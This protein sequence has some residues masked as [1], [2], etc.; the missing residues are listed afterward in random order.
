MLW[1]CLILIAEQG[2]VPAQWERA[3][4]RKEAVH[5]A[6]WLG[7]VG[8]IISVG[9]LAFLTG[10]I[11]IGG[12]THCANWHRK[13]AAAQLA[14]GP[15]PRLSPERD[16]NLLLKHHAAAPGRTARM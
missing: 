11:E 8:I 14:N 13:R 10:T 12:I 4:V 2:F 6:L 1:S 9:A 15:L 5:E 16:G 3:S 7:F